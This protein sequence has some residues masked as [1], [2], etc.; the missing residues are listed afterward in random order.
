MY[1]ALKNFPKRLIDFIDETGG[2]YGSDFCSLP[3]RDSDILYRLNL[4]RRVSQAVLKNDS[5]ATRLLAVGFGCHFACEKEKEENMQ[6]L[7]FDIKEEIITVVSSSVFTNAFLSLSR[8]L[9]EASK[10]S[11]ITFENENQYKYFA[12]ILKL[13]NSTEHKL[14]FHLRAYSAA[15]HAFTNPTHY[16]YSI[17]KDCENFVK[18]VCKIKNVLEYINI[19]LSLDKIMQERDPSNFLLND[20]IECKYSSAFSCYD[21]LAIKKRI[22]D[23]S[24]FHKAIGLQDGALVKKKSC[25]IYLDEDTGTRYEK[26]KKRFYTLI[27]SYHTEDEL[28]ACLRKILNVKF[29]QDINCKIM[30]EKHLPIYIT[31][32]KRYFAIEIFSHNTKKK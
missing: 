3:D 11:V 16:M 22:E 4:L 9:N 10:T 26:L 14:D 23:Y 6:D 1:I 19:L 12:T 20:F 28:V 21:D 7:F 30:K 13:L 8:K 2:L 5:L 32:L 31:F 27:L 15:V 24:F 17:M 29:Y 18:I 25:K